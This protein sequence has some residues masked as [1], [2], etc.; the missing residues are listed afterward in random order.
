MLTSDQR[1]HALTVEGLEAAMGRAFALDPE[2]RD[3]LCETLDLGGTE[4]GQLEQIADQPP[5]RLADDDAA[6]RGERLQSGRKVRRLANHGALLRL[7]L[8]HPLAD[9][10]EASRDPDPGREPTAAHLK[11]A[12]G[13][14][15][16]ETRPHRPLG[17]VLMRLR[18]AEIGQHT[19]AHELGD[20]ALEAQSLAGHGI[21]VDTNA[22]AHLLG[23]ERRRQRGRAH[24]IDEHHGQLPPLS[25]R[26]PRGRRGRDCGARSCML[27][28][29][30]S[31]RAAIA[32]RS[33]RRCSTMMTPMSL[34][35]SAV[36]FGRMSAAISFSWNAC[37]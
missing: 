37:S 13:S 24:K 32:S 4:V 15:N 11:P 19:V 27:G 12:D 2:G 29:S 20:V 18:P 9:H 16:G 33:L 23:I 17:V 36:S 25:R 35:S 3:G 7:A 5:G 31:A 10:H 22:R 30:S 21:L 34:R 14:D 26:R 28:Q 8:A 6:G 1:R